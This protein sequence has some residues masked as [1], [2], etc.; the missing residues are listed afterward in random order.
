[1]IA[2]RFIRE[3]L[4]PGPVPGV[5]GIA[6][7]QAHPGSRLSRLGRADP[8][9]WAYAWGGGVVLARYIETHPGLV[10]GRRVLDFGAGSGL[11]GIV[12]ARHGALVTAAEIDPFGQAAVAL[13]AAE[14]GV[15]LALADVDVEGPAPA[16]FEVILA[17]D[18]F[19]LP[20]I[21]AR[22]LPFLT[23][24]RQAGIEVLIGDPRRR[25]LPVA[26]LEQVFAETVTDM[27]GVQREAGVY[28]L[29]GRLASS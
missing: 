11:V 15:T 9:Y 14:N 1:L 21:A 17:G 13:N 5:P 23:R 3:H 2:T 19:Y 24:C 16:G 10:A 25:D 27:G 28:R 22:V 6:L 8:P 18:V 29:K 12:A 26:A 7:F 20:D 4:K